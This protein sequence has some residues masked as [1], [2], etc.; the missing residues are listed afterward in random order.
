MKIKYYY[1]CSDCNKKYYLLQRI[2][3]SSIKKCITCGGLGAK[4]MLDGAPEF[5]LKGKNW[6]KKD[7][8]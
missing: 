5:L 2:T 8:Y 3:E 4:R 7:G 1:E 6:E